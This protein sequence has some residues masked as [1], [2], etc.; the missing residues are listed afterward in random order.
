MKIKYA[1]RVAQQF[2]LANSARLMLALVLTAITGCT[3]PEAM[4]TITAGMSSG[5]AVSLREGDV[6][7]ISFPGAPNL[8]TTQPIRRDGR[9]TLPSLGEIKAAG[10]PPADLAKEISKQ[11]AAQLVSKE[12]SVMVVSSSYP[13]YVS[14]AVVR[15]GK[16]LSDHPIS[17]LEAIMEAGGF[18]HAKADLANVT[19]IREEGG[20]TKNIVVNLK[21]V[22]SGKQATPFYLKPADIVY[23]PAKFSWF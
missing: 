21:L 2:I 19:V 3:T 20:Q 23:V 22:L 15:P 16:V 9:I 13:V 6:L 11:F 5:E 18:D 10:L 14:G 1:I 4:N 12:V 17:V 8:D 7:K